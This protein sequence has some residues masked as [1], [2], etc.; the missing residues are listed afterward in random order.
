MLT[1]TIVKFHMIF[2]TNLE[3][4]TKY[5]FCVQNNAILYMETIWC[6]Q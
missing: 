5:M 2:I 1:S 3:S 4:E 6:Y